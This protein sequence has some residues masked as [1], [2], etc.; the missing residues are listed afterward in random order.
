V[1]NQFIRLIIAQIPGRDAQFGR[2]YPPFFR[3]GPGRK[4]TLR[5][6]KIII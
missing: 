4:T 3:R 5:I 2:L 1:D 6:K